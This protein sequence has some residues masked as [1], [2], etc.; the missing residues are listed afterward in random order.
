MNDLAFDYLEIRPCI[1]ERDDIISFA[2]WEEYRECGEEAH[3]W[4]IYGRDEKGEAH[5]IGDFETFEAAERIMWAI[6][7]PVWKARD[8][9]Q[10]GE[11]KEVTNGLVL[12]PAE[13][14]TSILEDAINQCSNRERL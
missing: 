1:Q 13:Q 11:D 14:A 3:F 6:Y 12:T 2:T 10:D 7:A 4:T 8:M 9:L 5:A